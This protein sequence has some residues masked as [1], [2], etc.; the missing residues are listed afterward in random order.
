MALWYLGVVNISASSI[1]IIRYMNL[2]HIYIFIKNFT[3]KGYTFHPELNPPYIF[4]GMCNH[5]S[6]QL[7]LMVS[8][9]YCI[10]LMGRAT[11]SSPS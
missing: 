7:T 8:C 3:Q 10:D 5:F 2:L 9:K 6:L 11:Q 1:G 4:I